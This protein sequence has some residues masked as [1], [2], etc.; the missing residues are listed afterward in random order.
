L[1]WLQQY[2]LALFSAANAT[3][4]VYG[5]IKTNVMLM[6][7]TLTILRHDIALIIFQK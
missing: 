1:K 3:P 5:I 6:R 2:S 7:K 4:V